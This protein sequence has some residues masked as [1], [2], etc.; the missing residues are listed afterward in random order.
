MDKKNN[1]IWLA[2]NSGRPLWLAKLRKDRRWFFASTDRILTDTFKK[3]L[4]V[5][6]LRGMDYLAPIPADVP[7]ILSPAGG[8]IASQPS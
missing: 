2:R 3:V 8:I 1:W 6:A 7:L 4:G 5:S